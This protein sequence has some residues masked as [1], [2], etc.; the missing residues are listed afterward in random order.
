MASKVG[1]ASAIIASAVGASLLIMASGLAAGALHE[2]T[3]IAMM[4][5]THEPRLLFIVSSFFRWVIA[6]TD[7]ILYISYT[8]LTEILTVY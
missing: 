8:A 3:T 4:T 2:V 5:T 6:L 1:V 7:I